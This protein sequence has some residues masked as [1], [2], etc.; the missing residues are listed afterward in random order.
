MTTAE[1]T[2]PV[3]TVKAY[4]RPIDAQGLAAFAEKGR[5]NP[6][7][8]GTNK[9]HTIME[10]QYRSLSYVGNHA[11]V[12][13]DEPLHLFGQDTAPAPGE[14]VLSGLG[15]CIAVGITAVATW[16]QVQLTKL[17]IF[18]EGDIGNPAAWGAGGALQKLPSEM[19]FQAI[20]VKVLVEGD[21]TRAELDEIVKH[22][23][24]YSPVANTLR[25]PIPFE[26]SLAD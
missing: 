13:V 2:A 17:E 4:L 12:V 19:G 8:R 14:I 11:P 21:A 20:R 10:G 5:G 22:A 7:S 3:N 25:N 16:K 24:F 1:I 15:G 6:A 18:L 26:I 9:V 23:N